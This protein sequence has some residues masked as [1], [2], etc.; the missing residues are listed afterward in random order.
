ME[1][2]LKKKWVYFLYNSYDNSNYHAKT[3][4]AGMESSASGWGV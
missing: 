4:R 2:L 1:Y 3:N